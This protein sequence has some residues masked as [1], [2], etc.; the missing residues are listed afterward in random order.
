MA[1]GVL[2]VKYFKLVIGLLLVSVFLFG[3]PSTFARGMNYSPIF[4]GSAPDNSQVLLGIEPEEPEQPIS[5]AE[6][7]GEEKHWALDDLASLKSHVYAMLDP[8]S[9]YDGMDKVDKNEIIDYVFNENHLDLPIK[10]RHWALLL[11]AVL[12]IPIQQRQKMLDMYV[13]NLAD[14]DDITRENAVGGM[15]KLLTIEM[16]KGNYHYEELAA[17]KALK[18]LHTVSDHQNTLV[19]IAYCAGLLDTN[20]VDYF[21]P[22]DKLTI[23]EAVSMLN[24][25]IE[26]FCI[27]YDETG[28]V[29]PPDPNISK[30]VMKIN[31]IDQRVQQYRNNLQQRLVKLKTAESI[32][33]DGRTLDD[34]SCVNNSVTVEKWRY[35]LKQVLEIDDD[36]V[37]DYYTTD[38]TDGP[39]V[40]RDVAVAGMVKL[41]HY[42]GLVPGRDASEQEIQR[43][44]AAF[45][46]LDHVFDIS[47]LAIAF[48][49]GLISGYPDRTC[50]PKRELT[51]GEALVLILNIIEKYDMM[52]PGPSQPY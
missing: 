19:Q 27:V 4:I 21:R 33:M 34:D 35:A 24:K 26:R 48:S 45:T 15:V 29:A 41:L 30:D 25:I 16:I 44:A 12:G 5:E 32:L 39:T 1:R 47:K 51:N 36:D 37:L 11:E 14:G 2:L 49:E 13:F 50:A 42:T 9:K 38:L 20:T 8:N 43:I 31:W 18:D 52:L 3:I 46:D 23:A 40:P 28:K 10:A 6:P 7:P 22:L 17:A